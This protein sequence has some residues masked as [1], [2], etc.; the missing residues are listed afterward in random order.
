[1]P[2]ATAAVNIAVIM[3]STGAL[4][5][6]QLLFLLQEQSQSKYY[7]TT[8]L[9]LLSPIIIGSGDVACGIG[10]GKRLGVRVGGDGSRL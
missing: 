10:S 8:V 7:F 3:V 1:M 9:L 6:F 5:R 4:V 2:A